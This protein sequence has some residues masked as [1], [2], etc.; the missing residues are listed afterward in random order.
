M[1]RQ[2]ST[3]LRNA[4]L[5]A[6]ETAIGTAPTLEIRTGTQPA[7]CAASDTGTALVTITLPS[8]WLAAASGGNKALL[9][10]WSGTAANT[11]TAGHYRI[12]QGGTCH[13]QGSV[14]M[15]TTIAT[16]ASTSANSNVLNHASTTGV[17]AGMKVTGT[18]IEP[19][20]YVLA[21][22]STTTTLSRASSAGVSNGASI[23]YG[24]DLN[25]QNTS[26]TSGQTVSISQFD[27]SQAGA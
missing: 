14:G 9:G 21:F 19:D 10:T 5:D 1:A 2:H 15:A 11:G 7:N 22:T 18:G 4:L 27:L 8:D 25:L 16:N 13:E 6:Y 12:K 3:A 20:T 23:T 26:I 17:A 24:F